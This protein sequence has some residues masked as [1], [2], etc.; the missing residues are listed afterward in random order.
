ML[1]NFNFQLLC[2]TCLGLLAKLA[3]VA[4]HPCYILHL[5]L[6]S[7]MQLLIICGRRSLGIGSLSA[8]CHVCFCRQGGC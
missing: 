8:P 3:I 1:P 4:M 2:F 7:D 5:Y 6:I